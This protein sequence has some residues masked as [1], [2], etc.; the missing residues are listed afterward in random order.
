[1][2]AYIQKVKNGYSSI[3]DGVETLRQS[4]QELKNSPKPYYVMAN[5]AALTACVANLYFNG[6]NL[7]DP[8]DLLFFSN[9]AIQL[10]CT[11]KPLSL[12]KSLLAQ[13]A[14]DAMLLIELGYFRPGEQGD[15]VLPLRYGIHLFNSVELH[16]LNEKSK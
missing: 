6:M 2:T 9:A 11:A 14:R 3:C 8:L 12:E 5:T 1:M 13:F 4:V 15:V 10:S 7:D 16:L